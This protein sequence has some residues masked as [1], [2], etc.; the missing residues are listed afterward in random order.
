MRPFK[1]TFRNDVLFSQ[2]WG[3][4][5]YF[6]IGTFAILAGRGMPCGIRI[7]CG[8]RLVRPMISFQRFPQSAH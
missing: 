5:L 7:E 4:W 8:G 2:A 1:I 6:H 3:S